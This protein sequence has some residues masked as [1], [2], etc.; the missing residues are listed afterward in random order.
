[1]QYSPWIEIQMTRQG[2]HYSLRAIAQHGED[3]AICDSSRAYDSAGEAAQAA[4]TAWESWTPTA[5]KG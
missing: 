5:R 1:M 2:W 3:I 4:Q